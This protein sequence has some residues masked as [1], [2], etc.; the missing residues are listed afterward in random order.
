MAPTEGASNLERARLNQE[1]A[2][3]GWTELQPFFARGV[4]IWVR[5]GID[6]LDMA[7]AV[8]ADDAHAVDTELSRGGI[9][10][11]TDAQARHWLESDAQ[12][13]AVVVKPWV[14]IQE[15]ECASGSMQTPVHG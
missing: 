6:L 1:T 4:L 5:P 7:L 15:A 10:R 14:L 3:I 13:W 11:V 2:R 9:A 8:S 12:L